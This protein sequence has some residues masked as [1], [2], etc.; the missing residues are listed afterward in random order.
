[1]DMRMIAILTTAAYMDGALYRV[2]QD[3]AE[4]RLCNAYVTFG[5]ILFSALRSRACHFGKHSES[6]T[7]TIVTT[8]EHQSDE[9]LM[10]VLRCDRAKLDDIS[11]KDW[12]VITGDD[13]SSGP[14]V[15]EMSAKYR[16]ILTPARDRD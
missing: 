12:I 3:S 1:M 16:L 14:I 4:I 2:K 7:L 11:W 5:P 15:E 10:H 6:D 13:H 8:E 9:L